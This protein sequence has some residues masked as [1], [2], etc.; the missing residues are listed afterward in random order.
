MDREAFGHL[1][2][3]DL[4]GFMDFHNRT[5]DTI[6]GL[7]PCA[8]L[9]AMLPA[10]A[11]GPLLKYSTSQ[12]TVQEDKDNSVSYLAISFSGP[13]WPE[14]PSKRMTAAE[15]VRLADVEKKTLIT[16]ARRGLEQWVRDHKVLDPLKQTDLTVTPAMMQC[17]GTFVTLY[18]HSATSREHRRVHE[19]KELRGCIGNIWPV[20]PLCQSVVENAIA[21]ST[22]DPRFSEVRSDELPGLSIEI[23]VLTPPRRV[24]SYHDV[25]LGT[26]GIILSKHD[27]QAVFL[28]QVATEF[29][30]DLP[31]T[32]KQLCQKAGLRDDDWKEGCHYDL[33]QSVS[34]EEN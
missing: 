22:R 25:V 19:D 15:A 11:H 27:K 1:A 18:K 14:H 21:S 29:G 30:W 16:I 34:L 33:F 4:P 13:S 26:D 7:F 9:C 12:D 31:E 6:C 17:F 28:P 8:V 32:L 20:R 23:S 2:T 3:G 24:N 5:E 10:Q